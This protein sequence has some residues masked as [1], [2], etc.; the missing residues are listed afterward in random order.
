MI[1]YQKMHQKEIFFLNT[2]R[3]SCNIT[4]KYKK[5]ILLFNI[6][7]TQKHFSHFFKKQLLAM[8]FNML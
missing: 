7:H 1:D 5:L 8:S 6:A 4:I 3:M 2:E